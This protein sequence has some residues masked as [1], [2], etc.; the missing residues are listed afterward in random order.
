M[1]TAT[2]NAEVLMRKV[3]RVVDAEIELSWLGSKHPNDHWFIE[4]EAK[5]ARLALRRY[6]KSRS[7]VVQQ[8][9]LRPL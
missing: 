5:A 3:K 4:N 7:G 1:T 6:L 2:V 8:H 9:W